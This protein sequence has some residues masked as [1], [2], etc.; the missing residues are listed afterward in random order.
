MTTAELSQIIFDQDRWTKR[1]KAIYL[2]GQ[3]EILSEMRDRGVLTA[4]NVI[5]ASWADDLSEEIERVRQM[6]RNIL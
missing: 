3:Y 2:Q 6:I 4:G 5:P 1:E